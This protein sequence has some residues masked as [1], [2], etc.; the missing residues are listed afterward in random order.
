MPLKKKAVKKKKE[1]RLK[2]RKDSDLVLSPSIF[3]NIPP[4]SGMLDGV[5][6]LFRS[7]DGP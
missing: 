1:V 5:R 3:E 4:P 2:R 7:A 6:N